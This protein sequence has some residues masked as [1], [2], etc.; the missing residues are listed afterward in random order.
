M[1]PVEF[2]YSFGPPLVTS[3]DL[4]F[5]GSV[6]IAE[7]KNRYMLAFCAANGTLTVYAGNGSSADSAGF[8]IAAG[9]NPVIFTHALHGSLPGLGWNVTASG[10]P[11]RVTVWEGKMPGAGDGNDRRKLKFVRSRRVPRV[12]SANIPPAAVVLPTAGQVVWIGER[13]PREVRNWANDREIPIL[14]D[15]ASGRYYYTRIG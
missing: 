1:T 15:P 3:Y 7:D 9:G 8:N 13:V 12:A 14:F 10:G 11:G 2:W 6:A 4:M 5:G